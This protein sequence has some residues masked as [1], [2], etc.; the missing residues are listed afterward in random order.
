MASKQSSATKQPDKMKVIEG[1]I[2]CVFHDY[3]R[4]D[5]AA[6]LVVR[7]LAAS[8][9]SILRDI[10]NDAISFLAAHHD[11]PDHACGRDLKD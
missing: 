5:E 7:H 8:G 1:A 11:S 6:E 9:Y 4:P 3:G 2:R 10:N